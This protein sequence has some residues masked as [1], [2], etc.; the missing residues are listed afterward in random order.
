MVN[1]LQTTLTWFLANLDLQLQ[2]L[3]AEARGAEIRLYFDASDVRDALLGMDAFYVPGG[4]FAVERFA[5]RETLVRSLAVS[6]WLGAIHML[7]PHQAEFLTLLEGDFGLPADA[8]ASAFA[9]RAHEFLATVGI[10]ESSAPRLQDL[11]PEVLDRVIHQQAGQATKF[12]NA[13]QCIRGVWPQ[14]LKRMYRSENLAIDTSRTDYSAL[15]D[16]SRFPILK[17]EFD[18]RRRSQTRNN[19]ADALAVHILMS[20]VTES[21]GPTPRHAPRFFAST[22]LFSRATR[23]AEKRMRQPEMRERHPDLVDLPSV[24][25]KALRTADYFIFKAIFRPPVEMRKR[26]PESSRGFSA[27]ELRE[28]SSRVEHALA[29]PDHLT[30]ESVGRIPI[31]GKLLVE[32]INDLTRLAFLENV[33]FPFFARNEVEDVRVAAEETAK[34]LTSNLFFKEGVSRAV[35]DAKRALK[36]NTDEYARARTLWIQLERL[37]RLMR[38]ERPATGVFDDVLMHFGLIRFSLPPA[39][40]KRI[41]SMLTDLISDDVN[42]RIAARRRFITAWHHGV[43]SA[44]SRISEVDLEANMFVAVAVLW[45]I[46]G[47]AELMRLVLEARLLPHSAL[48][49]MFVAAAL[50]SGSCL[51][52][53]D[54]ILADLIGDYPTLI[55]RDQGTLAVGLAYLHSRRWEYLGFRPEWLDPHAEAEGDSAGRALIIEAAR[56]AKHACELLR[57]ETEPHLAALRV[58]ATN[59]YLFYLVEAGDRATVSEMKTLSQ[60]LGA[61][62]G[63]KHLW[64]YR[65]DDTLAAYFQFLASIA[66]N[67]SQ[68]TELLREAFVHIV[69]ASRA[70]PGD[71]RV[72][73]RRTLIST[74]LG[75]DIK[76][77]PEGS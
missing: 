58:Y 41:E 29:H 56:Y 7:P 28:F 26:I 30:E 19:F 39:T 22:R 47:Y 62:H 10:H 25:S 11:P 71:P 2:D 74:A 40:H 12:F 14:R 21:E 63:Q 44:R 73:R 27:D 48:K 8:G 67:E 31:V 54:D 4:G 9:D 37:P 34:A 15:I 55:G 43:T 38:A 33:W 23:A 70:A 45:S 53:A 61:A 77:P 36:S 57:S 51:D 64:M 13:I 32:G 16:T 24:S 18:R 52:T 20:K 35:D 42:E 66:E 60:Q 69:S 3:A 50:Q 6:G 76:A 46:G 17:A 5:T 72:K 49:V 1:R 59:Q 65:Y 68:K 75:M